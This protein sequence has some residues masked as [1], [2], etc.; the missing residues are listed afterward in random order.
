M[1]LTGRNVAPRYGMR[2]GRFHEGIDL[3][4]ETGTAILAAHDG[5][6]QYSDVNGSYGKL[7]CIS[8]GAGFSTRCACSV[9]VQLNCWR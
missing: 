8:H 6:V 9:A 7:L 4:A 2:W 1:R 5:T 3:A